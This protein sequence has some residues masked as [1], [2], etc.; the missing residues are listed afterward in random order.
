MFEGS[1]TDHIRMNRSAGARR[2]AAA[3]VPPF[4]F[5][6][7][8]RPMSCGTGS[9]PVSHAPIPVVYGCLR[10]KQGVACVTA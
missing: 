8:R 4:S 6:D 5:T 9:R 10:S 7:I 2:T 3:I 1:A